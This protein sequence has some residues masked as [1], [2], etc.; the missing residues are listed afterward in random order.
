MSRSSVKVGAVCT[1]APGVAMATKY[2]TKREDG[3]ME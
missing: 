2:S 3:L 1:R